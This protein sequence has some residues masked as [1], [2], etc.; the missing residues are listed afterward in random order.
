MSA[1]AAALLLLCLVAQ[2][3]AA[4]GVPME[5]LVEQMISAEELAAV[6]EPSR[7]V[8]EKLIHQMA[9]MRAEMGSLRADKI[10]KLEEREAETVP[11]QPESELLENNF[12]QMI[13]DPVAPPPAVE[14][15]RLAARVESVS[16]GMIALKADNQQLH[17][18]WQRLSER[19]EELQCDRKD[20]GQHAAV[21]DSSELWASDRQS[22]ERRRAQR[23]GLGEAAAQI[24]KITTTTINCPLA[25]GGR[26]SL[27]ECQNPSFEYC[28][29]EVCAPILAGHRRMQTA[30]QPCTP[31]VLPTRTA[32]VDV[33][34][35]P[36]GGCTSGHPETCS[37]ACASVFLPWWRDCEVLLGKPGLQFL[38]TVEV[39]E[40][41]AMTGGTSSIAMQLG[42]QC[43][44]EEISRG[45]CIPEC[46]ADIHGWL[47]LL[48]IDGNDLKF[49][50]EIHHRLYS[51]LGP[52]GEGG[53][54]GSDIRA[55]ISA[56]NSAAGGL[57]SAIVTTTAVGILA[58]VDI[59][60]GQQVRIVG[61]PSLVTPPAWG[62]G[63]FTIHQDGE[64]TLSHMT[65]DSKLIVEAGS[66]LTLQDVIL[67]SSACMTADARAHVDLI[68]AADT[69]FTFH[70]CDGACGTIEHC[71]DVE[72][73]LRDSGFT[74]ATCAACE[75]GYYHSQYRDHAGWC[76]E[77]SLT[78][79]AAG[80]PTSFTSGVSVVGGRRFEAGEILSVSGAAELRLIGCIV[81]AA[82]LVA[83][84]TLLSGANSTLRLVAV[85]VPDAPSA[86]PLTGAVTVGQDGLKTIRRGDVVSPTWGLASSPVFVV[87]SGPCTLTEGG[88]CVGRADGYGPGESCDITV[89]GGPVGGLLD[90]C[91]VFDLN[92]YG[93]DDY[94]NLPMSTHLGSDCPEGTA[95]ATG[96]SVSW[97]S[98][99]QYQGNWDCAVSEL[100]RQGT[101]NFGCGGAS[102]GA[103]NG[104]GAKGLC[105]LPFTGKGPGQA[106]SFGYPSGLG[107]GWQ[108]CF[109]GPLLVSPGCTIPHSSNFNPAANIDDGSCT[110]G[111]TNP[112]SGNYNS[113]AVISDGS[114]AGGSCNEVRCGYTGHCDEDEYCA[115][116]DEQ[117]EVQCCSDSDL[118]GWTPCTVKGATHY[119]ERDAGEL[120]CTSQATLAEASDVCLAVGARLCTLVELEADCGADTGCGHNSK[121]QRLPA[122]CLLCQCTS[123]QVA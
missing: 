122:C 108:T 5:A 43:D 10:A 8:L 96:D 36:A 48:N 32:A 3:L 53:Y 114:C 72:C 80:A 14:R 100:R 83:A 107:G 64:L 37:A 66:N 68:G 63:G 62:T 39:C 93:K 105:G 40:A 91:G 6:P 54:I 92:A 47:M 97:H 104:C 2:P 75:N 18:R 61:D 103:D 79:E 90:G 21:F 35:C 76:I 67:N 123:V 15:R 12:A 50:C 88:R 27:T 113:G 71:T 23:T 60:S 33:A 101:N 34:C 41:M 112:T 82:V 111:C 59:Q 70:Q 106:R 30:A 84:E 11:R 99:G 98:N 58:D 94:I 42:V 20:S 26:P 77:E 81:P 29:Q 87:T 119:A 117:H 56:L 51:W 57:Y 85:T 13:D 120:S 121:C 49:S 95:L 1:T 7:T 28:N 115:F 74:V 38:P 44:G 19:V 118:G 52:A 22:G 16:S 110:R 86:G 31:D 65:I 55:L 46:D 116:R 25:S 45:D 102:V 24:I 69:R 109:A 9:A 17:E 73:F 78:L 89:I 4:R